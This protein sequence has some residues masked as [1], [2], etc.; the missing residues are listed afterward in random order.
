MAQFSSVRP[1]CAFKMRVETTRKVSANSANGRPFANNYHDK[2]YTLLTPNGNC[3]YATATDTIVI[4]TSR[5][6]QFEKYTRFRRECGHP[7]HL[8]VMQ[9]LQTSRWFRRRRAVGFDRAFEVCKSC[10]TKVTRVSTLSMEQ[11]MHCFSKVWRTLWFINAFTIVRMSLIVRHE[12][13]PTARLLLPFGGRILQRLIFLM[14]AT[15]LTQKCS[16]AFEL[17]CI[18]TGPCLA[19][20]HL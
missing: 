7:R 18:L 15:V 8:F 20:V 4:Q 14:T 11:S 16:W 9:L 13:T 17:P 2:D 19:S 10:M 5:L 3:S 1:D 6:R 12:I